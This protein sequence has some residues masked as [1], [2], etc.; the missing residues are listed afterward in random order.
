MPSVGLLPA[1]ALLA[2]ALAALGFDLDAD[3]VLWSVLASSS[4]AVPAWCAHARRITVATLV[5]GFFAAGALLTADAR[6]HALQTTLRA[7]LESRFSGFLMT[8][9][10]PE[11][12]HPPIP[13]RAVLLED[14]TPRDNYISLRVRVVA[15]KLSAEW[16]TADGG[17]IVS[18]SGEASTG[19]IVEWR[20]G[21]IVEAPM[22]FRRP[23]R[24]LDDGV[25]D[26]ERDLALDGITLLASVKSGL[27]VQVVAQGS[28]VDELAARVRAHVRR[29]IERWVAT[30]DPLSGAI[31]TAVLIGD[32]GGLTD[33]TRDLLQAAGTYHVI[34]IS[35]GNIAILAAVVTGLLTLVGVRDRRAALPAMAMLTLYALLASS[36]PSVWRATLMALL[37]FAARA[38][39]HRVPTWQAAAV[40]AALMIV[41]HPL[42]IRDPGFVLTFGATAAL[43]EGARH[44]ATL[45]PRSRALSWIAASVF[46]SLAVEA[47]LLPVSAQMFSRVT[48]AGLVLNL[49]AVPMTCAIQIA[50]LIVVAFDE[51]GWIA[52][53]AGWVAHAGVSAL[54]GSARLVLVAPWLSARVPAPGLTLMF[55]YYVALVVLLVVRRMRIIPASALL[56]IAIAI[57]RGVSVPGLAPDHRPPA[58]LRLT[59]FD[60][61]QGEAMLLETPL[62][63]AILIDAGGAPFGAAID[64]GQRVLAPALWARGIRSLETLLVTHGDPDHVGGAPAMLDD[65]SPTRMWEGIRVPVHAPSLAL[66]DL[67]ARHGAAM[68]A[69]RSGQEVSLESV[70]IRVLNPPAPDWERRRVR[71]DDSVVLE[72]IYGEVAILLTG[73]IGADVERALIPSL[74]PARVRVLKVAHHGSRTSTSQAL[75]DAWPP[76]VALISCGRGN[77]F[78]HPATEVVQRLEA[79]GATV[80]RTDRDG[81]ITI[82]TDGR[83]VRSRT[84]LGH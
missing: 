83:V 13:V 66:A 46:S 34:A 61:G 25:P 17:V 20:A 39:D 22:T 3:W 51:V 53:A 47:A 63:H 1:L 31:T 32:R 15:I 7:R 60:V 72:V 40:A 26:F 35:G 30:H 65:F 43:L 11:G 10:G 24:F 62:A 37:Y 38:L 4:A 33:E 28:L 64:I 54:V 67:A 81:Q 2:G 5:L 77:R 59:M 36:G 79:A 56:V 76:S 49:L 45:L 82:E 16:H 9:P 73:D 69:L 42:D 70:R 75:L 57:A 6:D 84:Y 8:S 19:R 74:T 23:T 68:I 52:A 44:G 80:M 18:V 41:A 29:A 78:G 27:L 71:N 21:R 58:W 14:A 12:E 55:A 48:S 50:G